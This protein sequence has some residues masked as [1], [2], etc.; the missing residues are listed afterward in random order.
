MTAAARVTCPVQ[1][2]TYITVQYSTGCFSL[3]AARVLC[4]AIVVL[5]QCTERTCQHTSI[6]SG[7]SGYKGFYSNSKYYTFCLTLKR[8]GV[9]SNN[10]DVLETKSF[11]FYTDKTRL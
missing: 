6:M 9:N 4:P 5:L 7:G 8:E 11:L 1:Y 3:A 10:I 2:S